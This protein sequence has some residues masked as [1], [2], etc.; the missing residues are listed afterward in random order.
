MALLVKMVGTC[1]FWNIQ[2]LQ[3]TTKKKILK[4]NE[5]R[6]KVLK[7][8]EIEK[9]LKHKKILKLEQYSSLQFYKLFTGHLT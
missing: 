4:E 7:K 9:S 8:F 5:L 6:S 3:I 2:T 1:E